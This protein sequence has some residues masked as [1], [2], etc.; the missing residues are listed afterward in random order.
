[1]SAVNK[2]TPSP[3]ARVDRQNINSGDTGLLNKLI[4]T[5]RI[6]LFVD[7]SKRVCWYPRKSKK[8]EILQH[9]GGKNKYR[10]TVS[11]NG[12]KKGTLTLHK[13][14]KEELIQEKK[15][16]ENNLNNIFRKRRRKK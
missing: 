10:A 15:G 9:R 6:T 11:T 7:P 1:V 4:R 8:S 12:N 16:Q 13:K 2:F 14:Q 3:P 5:S